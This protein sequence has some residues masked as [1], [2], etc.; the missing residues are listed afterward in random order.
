MRRV[1]AFVTSRYGLAGLVAL[2]VVVVVV[3]GRLMG[4]VGTGSTDDGAPVAG[5]TPSAGARGSGAPN[6]APTAARTRPSPVVPAG[7][8]GPVSVAGTFTTAYLDADRPAK[9]WRAALR[10]YA[11]T[12]LTGELGTMDPATVPAQRRTGTPTL[13]DN[14]AHWAQVD[15]P[16][17]AGTLTLRLQG[18]SAGWL[19]D[20]I[21]WTPSS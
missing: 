8:P 7:K 10:R 17:D 6:D 12:T 5:G 21:D 9:Q 18:E 4:V 3:V 1:L 14:G 2:L 19:V 16:T 13:T 11:T 15:V 20:G